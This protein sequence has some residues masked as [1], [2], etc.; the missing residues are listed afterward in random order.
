MQ[1]KRMVKR[2][3]GVVYA[4]KT[5]TLRDRLTQVGRTS[6]GKNNTIAVFTNPFYTEQD[7]YKRQV[8]SIFLWFVESMHS[9][10]QI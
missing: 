3:F 4:M 8:Q 7:V 1:N 10:G 2:Y 6:E 9:G 5:N